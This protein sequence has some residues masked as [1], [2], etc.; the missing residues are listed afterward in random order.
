[1]GEKTL[2]IALELQADGMQEIERILGQATGALNG[3]SQR[4]IT[5]RRLTQRLLEAR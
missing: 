3:H 5:G 2:A 1:V 4:R